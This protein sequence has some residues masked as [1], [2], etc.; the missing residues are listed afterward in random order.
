MEKRVRVITVLYSVVFALL[1]TNVF[2]LKK[3]EATN[4]TSPMA[5]GFSVFNL[6]SSTT[7]D[8]HI[9]FGYLP[10]WKLS[11]VEYIQLDKLTDV[12]YFALR[13]DADGTIRKKDAEGYIEP[14]YNKWKNSPELDW[15][16]SQAA[17]TNTRI[18]LSVI[19]HEDEVSDEFLDCRTCWDTL[20]G[21]IVYELNTKGLKHVNLDFEYVGYTDPEKADK[22]TQFAD[23]LNQNLDAIY[24]DSY[25]TV[26]TFAD[27]TIR[28]R[29]TK[30]ADLA[31]VVDGIFVMA[32]DFHQPTSANAGP[33][34][35]IAGGGK[36]SSY[37]IQT[38]L[39]DYLKH[40]PPNK[41][42]LGVAYYGYNWVVA[43]NEP[44]AT[45]LEGN[46]YNGYSQSQTYE[47]VLDTILKTNPLILWDQ[48]AQAPYFSYISPDT[49]YRRM[50]YYE[51]PESL[52][53]KYQLIK[54]RDLA[55]V[56][57]W[58]LGYDGGYQ[59]LWNLLAVNFSKTPERQL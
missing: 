58:A 37:D 15:L 3:T 51:N 30:P 31:K 7:R 40:I 2:L 32:Y 34:A 13:I 38:M 46:D 5:E 49:G 41:L 11:E 50:V 35:P 52:T 9:V 44:Y 36:Y 21:E 48:T 12:A 6:E 43:S 22:Y 59:D 54:S 28:P 14:G 55:G 19:S 1:V 29:V 42:I 47:G 56:G 20:L 16:I 27:S 45:R 57:I 23:F 8:D 24:T 25:V 53:A 17:K 18:S 10:Y 26:A 4:F 39:A 33:I